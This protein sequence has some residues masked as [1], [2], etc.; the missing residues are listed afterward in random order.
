MCGT[1]ARD[2]GP[3][4]AS[5]EPQSDAGRYI[6]HS[7]NAAVQA[8]CIHSSLARL[9]FVTV[10]CVLHFHLFCVRCLQASK[11]ESWPYALHSKRVT[12]LIHVSTSQAEVTG[13]CAMCRSVSTVPAGAK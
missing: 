10:V 3:S 11:L 4:E 13:S 12:N 1:G 6:S 5:P 7:H 2:S 9:L 8:Q